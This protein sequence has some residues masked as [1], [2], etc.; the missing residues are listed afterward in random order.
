M[1][2]GA[3][4]ATSKENIVKRLLTAF[5][6]LAATCTAVF[7]DSD[8]TPVP[9]PGSMILLGTAAAGIGYVTWRRNRNKK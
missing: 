4:A 9:E 2:S 5:S 3:V 8:L 6:L 1:L 7:A